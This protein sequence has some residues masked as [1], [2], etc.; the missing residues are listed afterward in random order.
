ML[1]DAN[2][3]GK[4]VK[5]ARIV[6]M[7]RGLKSDAVFFG[8]DAD[9]VLGGVNL[10]IGWLDKHEPKIGD[11]FVEGNPSFVVSAAEFE[12]ENMRNV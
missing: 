2:W 7:E 8:I 3:H 10:P 11:Y 12:R 5:A 4:I 1:I 9:H 6:S